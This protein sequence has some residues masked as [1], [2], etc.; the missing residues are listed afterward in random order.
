V[1]REKTRQRIVRFIAEHEE[2]N[3]TPSPVSGAMPR[4]RVE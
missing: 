2:R 1:V 4:W 3:H